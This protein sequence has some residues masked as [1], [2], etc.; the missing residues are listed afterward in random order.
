MKIC[1]E[2]NQSYSKKQEVKRKTSE[3]VLVAGGLRYPVAQKFP[4]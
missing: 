1:H 4:E 2:H 3:Y